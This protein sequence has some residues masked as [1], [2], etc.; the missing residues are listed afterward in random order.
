MWEMFLYYHQLVV[1]KMS[2][3]Q[4]I[5]HIKS[6]LVPNGKMMPTA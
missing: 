2:G 3:L 6:I 4:Q 5:D 1:Q